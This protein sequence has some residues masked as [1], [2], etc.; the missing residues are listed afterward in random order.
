[1]SDHDGWQR[2]REGVGGGGVTI[3]GQSKG[4]ALKGG[5]SWEIV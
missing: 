5:L 3:G 4:T 2:G 1:M